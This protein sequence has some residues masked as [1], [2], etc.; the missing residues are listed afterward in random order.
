MGQWLALVPNPNSSGKDDKVMIA[1]NNNNVE[2]YL[3]DK[4][5]STTDQK[6]VDAKF[7]ISAGGRVTQ[8]QAGKEGRELDIAANLSKIEDEF[9]KNKKQE[10][11]LIINKL[12]P[13]SNV[14]DVN[15][16]GIK[17]IIGTG[18][19]TFTGSPRNRVK[20]IS[21][22]AA[23][24]NGII[25]KPGENFSLLKTLGKIDASNGYLQELVIKEGKTI[26]EYGGGLCQ[27]GT[28][29]F[30]A[31]V[32]SGL[33]IVERRNHS[34]RV[35][36]YEPAGTDATIYDPAPDFKFKND[37]GNNILI[38]T[39]IEGTKLYFDIWGTKDERIAEQTKPTI[40]NIVKPKPTKLIE[41]TDLPAGKKKCTESAHNGADA[42]FDYKVTYAD[43]TIKK[44]RFSS[45]YVPWQEV[46][47]IGVDKISTPESSNTGT[48]TASTTLPILSST[49]TSSSTLQ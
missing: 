20:N 37:T 19:S 26:P 6:L 40:Y 42:F 27:I 7:Q 17:E 8:F 45:H 35:S 32:N 3:K 39:R 48:S 38:Q 2:K 5:A 4:V 21:I 49:T 11:E 44:E 15:T 30:R 22:G 41:T 28:T 36:Y 13:E 16:L 18:Q 47:L 10:I 23:A 1:L 12:S 33:P 29:I 9:I 25:V 24:L 43:G 31:A 14:N 34:Y 46:C